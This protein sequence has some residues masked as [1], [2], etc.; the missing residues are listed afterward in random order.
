MNNLFIHIN[1]IIRKWLYIYLN[2]SQIFITS[3]LHKM[4]VLVLHQFY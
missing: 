1:N 4:L 3:F 2:L